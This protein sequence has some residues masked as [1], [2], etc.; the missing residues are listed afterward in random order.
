MKKIVNQFPFWNFSHLIKPD[1]YL[2]A[3]CF[4][5]ISFVSII[6]LD[7]KTSLNQ[8]KLSV[9]QIC[10]DQL[11]ALQFDGSPLDQIKLISWNGPNF[12][13]LISL[14]LRL[15]YHI[16]VCL[17]TIRVAFVSVCPWQLFNHGCLA[18]ASLRMG[19]CLTKY[20]KYS[21][22]CPTT[23]CASPLVATFSRFA[24]GLF[25]ACSPL[26]NSWSPFV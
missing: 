21:A 1:F 22:T 3:V 26:V 2:K 24:N 9:F 13:D 11:Y 5:F 15:A 6:F 14:R 4:V 23:G 10:F 7:H 19:L 25:F 8:S 17:R 12:V 20:S 18:D 16:Q